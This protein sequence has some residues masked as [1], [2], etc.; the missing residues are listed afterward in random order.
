M[1][2]AFISRK[3]RSWHNDGNRVVASE[4][5]TDCSGFKPGGGLMPLSFNW[6]DG[7]PVSSLSGFKSSWGLHLPW[8]VR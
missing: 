6:Q 3:G 1:S 7:C 4:L 8:R 2:L 5:A